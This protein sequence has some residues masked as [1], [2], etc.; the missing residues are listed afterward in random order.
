MNSMTPTNTRNPS[1][2]NEVISEVE[3]NSLSATTSSFIPSKTHCK[4]IEF[5]IND[6]R[7]TLIDES[8]QHQFQTEVVDL[9]SDGYADLLIKILH[10]E[11]AQAK[12][13]G[14]EF[15]WRPEFDIPKGIHHLDESYKKY[16]LYTTLSRIASKLAFHF[17]EEMLKTN[18]SIVRKEA[19]NESRKLSILP[20]TTAFS[21]QIDAENKR[22][23]LYLL[24][25]PVINKHF[26]KGVER[27]EMQIA[28]VCVVSKPNSDTVLSAGLCQCVL[29][30]LQCQ[31]S[32]RF[33]STVGL[34]ECICIGRAA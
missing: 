14:I 31:E 6:R 3:L 27:E 8:K 32:P 15:D 29:T 24:K 10:L 9:Y 2:Y 25:N 16:P 13:Y 28:N 4:N 7:V 1:R 20:L 34:R 33:L 18:P 23:R 22:A 17:Y 26:I 21:M 12:D 11:N 5:K 30:N 19:L